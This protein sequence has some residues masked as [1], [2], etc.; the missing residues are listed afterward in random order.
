MKSYDPF[1]MRP[2]WDALLEIYMEVAKVC[3]RYGLRYW[4][5]EGNAIGALRHRGFVPWDDDIDIIMPRPD[6]EKFV[7]VAESEL[8]S[9]LKHWNWRD[10]SEWRFT[11]GKV[12][13]TRESRVLEV[14]R[15]VGHVL[16]NGLYI[17]I[18][19]L[20]GFPE[21]RFAA[22]IYKFK[23][24][25]LGM[26]GRYRRTKLSSFRFKGKLEWLCGSV[27]SCLW[28]GLR[29]NEDV[30]EKIEAQMKSVPFENAKRTWRTGASIRV[31]MTFPR[32]IWNGT[33]MKEFDEIEVPLPIGYDLY[34]RTQ[35]GD[36]MRPPELESQKPSHSFGTHFP[37][38]LGPMKK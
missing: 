18:L 33:V 28:P 17:D 20:D 7:A 13:D 3:D 11:M 1:K 37:W 38:W 5:A 26:I 14:E 10:V 12:Q 27:V 2:Q 30:M 9:Y 29:T 16:S 6:Y 19:I 35:Y 15:E 25:L 32:K 36:Y 24:R 8:P 21:G 34:L 31:T 22:F 4:F 23:M